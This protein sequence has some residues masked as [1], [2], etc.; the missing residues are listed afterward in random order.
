MEILHLVLKGKWYDMIES[1]EKKEEYRAFTPYW[2]NRLIQ[3]YGMGYWRDIFS[4]N[5]IEKL[6]RKWSDGF[7]AVFGLN[8][9]RLYDVI[10]FHRGYTNT[11]ISFKKNG[12]NIDKGNTEWGAP[13]DEKVF[14]IELGERMKG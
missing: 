2:C 13:K 11:T 10:C 4:H 9:I 14:I 12:I 3:P 1:G 7:P 5:S 8:G 6:T